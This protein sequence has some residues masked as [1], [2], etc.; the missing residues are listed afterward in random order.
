MRILLVNPPIFDFTAYDFW[1]QPYGLFRVAGRMQSSCSLSYFNFLVSHPRDAWGR[2]SFDGCYIPKPEAFRDIPR[3]FRRYGKPRE[4]FRDYL[5][6]HPF[7]AVLIQTTMTYWYLGIREVVEDVRDLQP[8]AKIILGGVYASICPDHARSLGADLVIEGKELDPLWRFLSIE[9]SGDLPFPWPRDQHYG[10]MKISEGCPFQCTYCSNTLTGQQFSLHPLEKSVG[11]LLQMDRC[12]IR[13]V[14]FYDDALLYR[15]EEG[16]TPFLEAV[17]DSNIRFAFHTPNALNA[18]LMTADIAQL[19]VRAGFTSFFIGLESSSFSWQRA[20]GG[21]VSEEDFTAA[22]QYLKEAGAGAVTTY[23]IVGHPLS[24]D[25]NVEASIELAHAR[26]TRVILSE[27]S[28][29]PGTIDGEKCR[30][31]ADLKDPLSHNK[32]A[33]AIRR[34]GFEELNRL[35]TLAHSLNA[36]LSS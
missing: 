11:E 18:R 7:D 15:S 36:A 6:H 5:L 33:F 29:I 14:A 9:P 3:R 21:K 32:T 19:M 12:G 20:T 13:N 1:L 25:Q 22:V 8:S 27:F 10:V 28:P 4:E 2:G 34:L 17:L 24:D 26:G 35:K 16:L 30:P 23:I 31:W